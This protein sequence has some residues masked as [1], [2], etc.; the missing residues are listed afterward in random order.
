MIQ[1]T[2]QCTRPISKDSN[3]RKIHD[4]VRYRLGENPGFRGK[5]HNSEGGKKKENKGDM[6]PEERLIAEALDGLG[7][8]YVE[9]PPLVVVLTVVAEKREMARGESSAWVESVQAQ[10]DAV[11]VRSLR[12]FVTNAA[13]LNTMLKARGHRELDVTTLTMMLKEVCDMVMGTEIV[14]GEDNVN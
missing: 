8:E 4:I 3:D 6:E 12:Q 10:M 5:G 9:V 11:G 2:A 1:C 7:L 14:E 13:R